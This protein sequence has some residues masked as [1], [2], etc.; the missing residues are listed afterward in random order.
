[1]SLHSKRK[2]WTLLLFPCSSRAEGHSVTVE[3]L[4]CPSS[5]PLPIRK[6]RN[7]ITFSKKISLLYNLIK[8]STELDSIGGA[9][10]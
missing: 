3:V 2:L 1:M 4:Q 8:K 7:L 6:A 9:C 10:S 5:K